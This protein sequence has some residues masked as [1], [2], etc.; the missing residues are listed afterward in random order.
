MPSAIVDGMSN[1]CELHKLAHTE[2]CPMC[3][4]QEEHDRQCAILQERI[5]QLTAKLETY[6]YERH[7]ERSIS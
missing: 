7:D 5:E 1:F 2:G 4:Q 6:M 3:E